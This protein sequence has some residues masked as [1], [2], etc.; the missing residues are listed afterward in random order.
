[1]HL[2]D[3]YFDTCM[4]KTMTALLVCIYNNWCFK[5]RHFIC[6]S[7][8][9]NISYKSRHFICRSCTG[10]ISFKSLHF[11]CRSCTGNIS[12]KSRHFICR[13]CTGNILY[14]SRRFICRSCT[15]N[16]LY[17]SRRF[18]CRSYSGKISFNYQ[19]SLVLLC[20]FISKDLQAESKLRIEGDQ[21][22]KKSECS[23]QNHIYVIVVTYFLQMTH[24]VFFVLLELFVNKCPAGTLTAVSFLTTAMV[25]VMKS[26]CFYVLN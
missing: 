11:I 8:T 24:A 12:F 19:I 21:L 17:K 9:G 25:H 23:S 5:S 3:R 14:K 20:A 7:C 16:I 2:K 22:N 26:P 13:S 10:N 4:T 15:G 1:M 18:I 6:R